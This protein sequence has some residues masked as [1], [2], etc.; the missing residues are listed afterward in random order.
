M[1][2]SIEKEWKERRRAEGRTVLG[3]KRIEA[4]DP[5]DSPEH[6]KHALAP[7]ALAATAEVY[8]QMCDRYH[9]LLLQYRLAADSLRAGLKAQFPEGS[10]PPPSPFIAYSRA[11]PR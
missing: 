9:A 2:Q 6:S 1:V 8:R 3:K 11:G 5:L 10:F 4:Q 7:R